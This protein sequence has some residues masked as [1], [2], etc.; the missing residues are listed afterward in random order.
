MN[1]T[2][3]TI[4][5]AALAV[6]PA[7]AQEAGQQPQSMKG[8]VRKRL[9]PVS[10][11]VLQVRLPKP[12]ERKLADGLSLVVVENHKLPTVV[13]ELVL[14]AT[15]LNESP[16]ETGVADC[17][18]DMMKAGTKTRTAKQIAEQLSEMGASLSFDAEFGSQSTRVTASTLSS[19]LDKLIDLLA[20]VLLN[21]AFPQDELDK[22]KTRQLT[23]LQQVRASESF[24]G[25]ERQRALL[26]PDDGRRLVAPGVTEIKAITREKLLAFYKA[27]YRPGNSI[28]GVSGDVL[29]A[30]LSR[31]LDKALGGWE[32]GSVPEPKVASLAPIPEKKIYLVDRPNSVQTLLILT[33]RAIDRTS[34]DYVAV[35]VMNRVLGGGPAGR[36]FRNIRED[37]GY[38]YGA[39]SSFTSLKYLAYFG[40]SSSVRTDVTEP[41]LQEFL[42]EFRDIRDKPVPPEELEDA[43][44]AIVANFALGLERQAFVL[45][46]ILVQKEYTLPADYWDTY[47]AKVMAVTA[48]DVERVAKKYI[49]LDNVQ[50]VAVGDAAK[51]R[52]ALAK[53]GPVEEYTAEGVKATGGGQ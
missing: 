36:L 34:P 47:P 33:N 39:S 27:N 51:I 13:F 28:L 5:L 21:P 53:F 25:L 22:W 8:V 38:T 40:A 18:A 50:V 26:Y 14:P 45:S 10:T 49:P 15:N 30:P 31:M 1:R 32:A 52:T 23:Q 43:K 6:L 20:D 2:V 3:Q 46:Q 7:A 4:A 16:G 19:N 12:L 29:M 24:L 41:A 44:R 11:E 9:A 48:A 37:K 35:Q 42:N 17:V